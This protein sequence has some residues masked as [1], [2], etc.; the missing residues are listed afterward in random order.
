MLRL[1]L[2]DIPNDRGF[3]RTEAGKRMARF[4]RLHHHRPRSQW[5]EP[6]QGCPPATP[7]GKARGSRP[8]MVRDLMH[9]GGR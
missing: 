1:A 8:P 2:S 9:T 5:P 7:R 3:P 6:A 4:T